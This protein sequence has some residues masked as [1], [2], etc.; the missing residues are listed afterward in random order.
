MNKKNKIRATFTVDPDVFN[1]FVELSN[2]LGV[3]RSKLISIYIKK[4][5]QENKSINDLKN[6]KE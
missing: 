1:S 2:K 5:I 6:D 4:W 3:S